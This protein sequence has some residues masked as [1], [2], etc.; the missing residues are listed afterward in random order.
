LASV[1]ALQKDQP[2]DVL[3]FR[4]KPI[5]ITS[6]LLSFREI[7]VELQYLFAS[8][9]KT[10]IIIDCGSNI[11]LSLL[12]FKTLY[13]AGRVIAFEADPATHARLL[14]NITMNALEGVDV[15][16]AAVGGSDGTIEFYCGSDEGGS[17]TSSTDPRRG[18]EGRAV[19]VPQL[20]LSPFIGQ[21]VDFLKL[22][23]EGAEL[24]VLRELVETGA[25]KRIDQMVVEVH[26]HID[27]DLDDCSEIL[28][29]L[30]RNGFGYQVEAA[31]PSS[32]RR[33][34]GRTT[35]DLLVFAYQK[36]TSSD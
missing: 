16:F 31:C 24:S 27:P 14:E 28:T 30:E 20:R 34:R 12:F 21:R 32:S 25:I 26:H 6:L 36:R 7:F 33:T 2:V 4:V 13:P 29:M 8:Q 23:I 3:D 1:G 35:Q 19:V 17:L 10:P 15:H 11:G 18:G 22:D 9:E 5:S